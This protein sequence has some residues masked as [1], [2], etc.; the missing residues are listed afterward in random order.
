MSD[1]LQQHTN[2]RVWNALHLSCG[3]EYD[4]ISHVPRDS[5]KIEEMLV[6]LKILLMYIYWY[7]FSSMAGELGL[8][9]QPAPR[10]ACTSKIL[11]YCH[12][13]FSHFPI[14]GPQWGA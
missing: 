2:I 4:H 6:F 10:Q 11:L 1:M 7:E 14:P 9:V 8:S 3:S 12:A 5:I 13:R